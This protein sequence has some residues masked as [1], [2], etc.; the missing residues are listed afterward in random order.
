[1]DYKK[2]EKLA[3]QGLSY[4]EIADITHYG[5]GDIVEYLEGLKIS[6]LKS[7]P[8]QSGVNSHEDRRREI[9][10]L[11]LDY[12]L[13]VGEIASLKGISEAL[14]N[15]DL[16]S[17]GIIPSL[18]GQ[19][20]AYS[21]NNGQVQVDEQTKADEVS[22]EADEV[23]KIIAEY[24][25]AE[26]S[27]QERRRKIAILYRAGISI[28]TIYKVFK[29]ISSRIIDKDIEF[30][31]EHELNEDSMVLNSKSEAVSLRRQV[32]AILCG[33]INKR[34]IAREIGV[35]LSTVYDDLDFLRERGMIANESPQSKNIVIPSIEEVNRLHERR[36]EVARLCGTISY[37]GIGRMLGVSKETVSDDVKYLISMGII[38]EEEIERRKNERK[39][40]TIEER[41]KQIEELHG[42]MTQKQIASKLG[43]SQAT[44][45]YYVKK[46]VQMGRIKKGTKRLYI[47]SSTRKRRIEE[48]R[49]QVAE[50]YRKMTSQGDAKKI[51]EQIAK[52]TGA[53]KPTIER[54]IRFLRAQGII[55]KNAEIGTKPDDY[56]VNTDN[57]QMSTDEQG[58]SQAETSTDAQN[59][60]EAQ[61]STD[62]QNST[63]VQP[64]TNSQEQVKYISNMISIIKKYYKEGNIEGA[65]KCLESIKDKTEF[66]K[67]NYAA[68]LVLRRKLLTKAKLMRLRKDSEKTG[69][70]EIR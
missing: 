61:A 34:D 48:R 42:K 57:I 46:L 65:L 25:G 37:S 18:K 22:D 56:Q 13:E 33:K 32:V 31:E 7:K 1:M 24:K 27:L 9:R 50:L 70:G 53:S 58:V 11:F 51:A 3:E 16:L 60:I 28:D 19:V 5:L 62:V 64:T 35:S 6:K 54:D 55:D 45:S 59:P 67:T 49:Q 17:M 15:E 30:I 23:S 36:M 44:V 66:S 29:T 8:N 69:E 14:V 47:P 52:E 38:S 12:D 40:P 39:N 2:I 10:S 4:G 21:K 68:Y 43:I 41:M 26:D 20:A 63:V